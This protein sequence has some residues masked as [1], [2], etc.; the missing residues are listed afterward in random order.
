MNWKR[1]RITGFKG[2]CVSN[3]ATFV[4]TQ[5]EKAVRADKRQ[6]NRLVREYFPESYHTFILGGYNP[7]NYYRNDTYLILVHSH[8][9]HFFTYETF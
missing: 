9:E 4:N 8:I 2:T 3:S 7:Y 1:T 5:L 6:I